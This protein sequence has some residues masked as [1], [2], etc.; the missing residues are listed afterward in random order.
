M[1]FFGLGWKSIYLGNEIDI[2][3]CRDFILPLLSPPLD[4][5]QN[6]IDIFYVIIS[7]I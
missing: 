2:E 7:P 5:L 1:K 4:K 3:E 6:K